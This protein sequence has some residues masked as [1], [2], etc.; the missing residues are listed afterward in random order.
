MLKSAL[1][2]FNA[3][4]MCYGQ[5]GAGKTYTMSGGRQ[6]FKERG[7]I[8]RTLAALFGILKQRTNQVGKTALLRLHTAAH[9]CGG[10]DA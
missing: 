5:T 9:P 7:I 3:T 10:R 8:P 1:E 6:G 2:G 4:I